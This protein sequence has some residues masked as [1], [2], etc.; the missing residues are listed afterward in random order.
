MP[1]FKAENHVPFCGYL[2]P[3]FGQNRKK[4]FII[5]IILD[6]F[7]CGKVEKPFIDSQQMNI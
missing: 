7:S 3:V 1:Y 2:I 6:K 5:S 4:V